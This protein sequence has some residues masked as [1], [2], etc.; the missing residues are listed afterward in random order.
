VP[1]EIE[2]VAGR[3]LNSVVDPKVAGYPCPAPR[4]APSG[5]PS[6]LEI[7]PNTYHTGVLYP[8]SALAPRFVVPSVF[9]KTGWV[10]RQLTG[11][12]MLG[13]LDVSPELHQDLGSKEVVALCKSRELPERVA[14]K[15]LDLF[16]SKIICPGWEN[17]ERKRPRIAETELVGGV[18]LSANMN[19]GEQRK[20]S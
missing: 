10:R 3:D 14:V 5:R 12:E 8:T 11:K 13:A 17:E 16:F 9:S 2:A 19:S 6:V 1:L 18:D 15:I 20:E 4:A 7:R